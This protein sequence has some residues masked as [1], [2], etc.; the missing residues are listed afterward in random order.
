MGVKTAIAGITFTTGGKNQAAIVG[1]DILDFV[2]GMQL[3]CQEL[4]QKINFLINDV[5]TPAGTEGANITTLNTQV[6]NLS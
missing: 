6:T 4:T 2:A 5:L 3:T 1:V